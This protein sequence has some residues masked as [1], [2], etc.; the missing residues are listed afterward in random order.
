MVEEVG[1]GL[2]ADLGVV[3][4]VGQF[5]QIFNAA[6][7]FRRAFGFE[8]LDV[9]GA[10]DE[11][12]DELGEGGG[13]AGGAETFD[14]AGTVGCGGVV[15][16]SLCRRGRR[17]RGHPINGLGRLGFWRHLEERLARLIGKWR[18]MGGVEEL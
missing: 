8:R 2:A 17:D 7:G 5:L 6:E 11:E 10:V 1:Q 16:R 3:G 18:E 14:G 15:P 9:A 13:V 4:G 12:T